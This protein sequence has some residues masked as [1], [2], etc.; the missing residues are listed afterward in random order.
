[1]HQRGQDL[2]AIAQ[3]EGRARV[4]DVT[5]VAEKTE[6]RITNLTRMIEEDRAR[7]EAVLADLRR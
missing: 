5:T 7:R 4:Q 2:F 6:D 3:S 1:M